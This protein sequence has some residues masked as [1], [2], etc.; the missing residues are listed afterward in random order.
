VAPLAIGYVRVSSEQQAGEKQTSLRDQ[1][2][3]ISELATR[4]GVELVEWFEDAGFSG[5]TVA[6][7]PALRE[8]IAYCEGTP[9]KAAAPGYVLVLNDS[10]FG[11]FS[12]PDEAVALRFQLKAQGWIV[13][14]CEADDVADPSIRHIMRAVGGAEAS[15][16]R[17]NLRANSTRGRHGTVRQGFWAS[18]E[19]FGYRRKVVY[20]EGQAR[21]LDK[22][23]PKAKGEKIKLVPGPDAEV[24]LVREIFDRYV[25]QGQSMRAIA[26]WL[27]TEPAARV[28][29]QRW[30]VSTLR[31]L[32][33]NQAYL[34]HIPARRRT[35]E[36]MEQGD[37]S[38]QAPE[39][40]IA[41]CHPA[42]IEEGIYARAQEILAGIPARGH[43][44]DYRVRGL[45]TCPDCGEPF[46]GGGLGNRLA[47]TGERTRFYID[48]GGRD[49]RCTPPAACVSSHLLEGAVISGLAEH[50]TEQLHPEVIA[51]AMAARATTVPKRRQD[52]TKQRTDLTRRL[53]RLL[54][55]IE[56]GTVLAD[57]ASARLTALRAD[58]AAI[59]RLPAPEQELQRARTTL[60][61]LLTVATDFAR[62][63]QAATGAELRTMLH[64]WVERMTFHR[65][66]RELTM[67][68]RPLSSVLVPT[69]LRAGGR[70]NQT[71]KLVTKVITVSPAGSVTYAMQR[72]GA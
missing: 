47:G 46:V 6:K 32:L 66:T 9:Q 25:L 55:A 61:Q 26:Q 49:G 28:G 37:Y 27:N 72:R 67:M 21:V 45:V 53:E 24:A 54:D 64:P 7:R 63:A 29:R 10:R 30:A 5:A 11:R 65:A 41:H 23:V 44:H 71:P 34:G 56:A 59:D 4:L 17:S 52:L 51:S 19:P 20:P 15:K 2:T 62:I 3:A 42:L 70:R 35:S 40:V 57:E 48:R 12:D 22:G 16:Y 13:R 33:E 43:V 36:R 38:R 60:T 8:L 58:I 18:R 68:L 69:P 39:Y 1:R 14:F 31:N 50:L